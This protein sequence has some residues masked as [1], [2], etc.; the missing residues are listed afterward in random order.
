MSSTGLAALRRAKNILGTQSAIADLVGVTQPHVSFVLSG[1]SKIPADWC[2]PI[3][4]ATDGQVKRH[5]LRPDLYPRDRKEV[6]A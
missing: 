1:K 5:E 4:T 3:E 2:I 6:A